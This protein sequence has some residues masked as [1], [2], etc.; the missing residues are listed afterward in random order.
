MSLARRLSA[1]LGRF[2]RATRG[3]AAVEFA[4]IAPVMLIMLFG[5]ID[6][7][8]MLQANRR[9]QNT[10]AS[11]SDVVA[12]DTAVSNDE[13]AG[14]WAATNLLMFPNDGATLRVRVTSV[15]IINASTA[16]V[17]WSEARG[18]D[19]LE[20]GDPVTDLP[21]QMMRPGSSLIWTETVLPY[22]SPLGFLAEGVVNLRHNA[23]RRSRLVDPIPRVP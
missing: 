20:P 14:L 8:D 6:L 7:L 11:L 12:R 13:V 15:R 19:K 18:L 9:A 16:E 2:A 10:A 5:S 22:T 23:Y 21:A 1:S 17:V 4:V 3:L